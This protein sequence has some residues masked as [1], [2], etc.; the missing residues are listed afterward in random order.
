MVRHSEVR[1]PLTTGLSCVAPTSWK[2]CW[3][4]SLHGT[5]ENSWFPTLLFHVNI[6]FF[7]LAWGSNTCQTHGVR[8]LLVREQGWIS[9][10]RKVRWKPGSRAVETATLDK[11]YS[12]TAP[13]W[14][15]QSGPHYYILVQPTAQQASEKAMVPTQLW[16]HPRSQAGQ[17]TISIHT[18]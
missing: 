6:S 4:W 10:E 1:R 15:E 5:F 14:E 17:V 12:P 16:C 13:K 18:T 9:V 3:Q 8:R 11:G 7:C 2:V